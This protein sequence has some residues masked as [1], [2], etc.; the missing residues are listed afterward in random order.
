MQYAARADFMRFAFSGAMLLAGAFPSWGETPRANY[1][2][3]SWDAV[4]VYLHFGSKTLLSDEDLKTVARLTNFICLEKAH[5]R[6]SVGLAEQGIAADAAKLKQ[7]NPRIKVLFYWNTFLGYPFTSYAKRFPSEH[8]DWV[9]RDGK[10]EPIYKTGTLIQYNLLN[11][12]LRAWWASV[13]GDAVE[14][15]HCDGI[16]MDA[17]DQSKRPVWMKKGW[18]EGK[19]QELTDAA[20][21]M[22]NRARAAMG[23]GGLIIYNGFAANKADLSVKGRDYIDYADGALF[24]HFDQFASDAKECILSDWETMKWAADKGKITIIKAWPDQ[25]FNW[26]DKDLMKKPYAELE[27]MAREKITY[28][29]ACFLIGA[30][31]YS[32]FCYSWGYQYEHGSLIHYPEYYKP[33]GKPRS[34]FTRLSPDGW[35][36]TREFEHASVWVDLAN[37]KAR[38]DWR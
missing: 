14:K 10:G 11:P 29:L 19:E 13:A 5:G 18:G 25:G 21:D 12:D 32:Y 16:F 30:R 26:Q 27:Q 2:V 1:P 34:D 17:V 38:I 31:D 4:P 20:I 7:L 23:A 36:F 28:P 9:F 24:E 22:M 35:E 15:Y 6:D 33:L 37:R 8:P 3:F